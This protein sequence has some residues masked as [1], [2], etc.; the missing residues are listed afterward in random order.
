MIKHIEVKTYEA[1]DVSVTVKIDYDQKEISL[2]EQSGHIYPQEKK[3]EPK[4]WVFAHRGL[5]YMGGWENI[6]MS[7]DLAIKEAS[8]DLKDYIEQKAKE[9]AD[10]VTDILVEASRIVKKRGQK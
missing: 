7:M 9:K 1:F 3:F 5:E 10:E 4:K 2:V 8:K 6:L